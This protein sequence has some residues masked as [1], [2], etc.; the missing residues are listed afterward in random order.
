MV[1]QEQRAVVPPSHGC[2]S[3]MELLGALV[4]EHVAGLHIERVHLA[5]VVLNFERPG[6]VKVCR[7]QHICMVF[8]ATLPPPMVL[9]LA[10]HRIM[11]EAAAYRGQC[12][13]RRR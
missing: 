11:E 10:N 7:S 3:G 8:A 12:G 2:H 1:V 5:V 4:E 6:V 13:A 9:P